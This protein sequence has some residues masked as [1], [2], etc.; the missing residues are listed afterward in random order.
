MGNRSLVKKIEKDLEGLSVQEQL[1]L[2]ER[3]IR[4]LKERR[5]EGLRVGWREL[6][7]LGQGL[8]EVDAQ[9]YVNALREER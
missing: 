6:Y 1:E 8:W 3:V 9:E 4:K 2:L 5:D 7:G